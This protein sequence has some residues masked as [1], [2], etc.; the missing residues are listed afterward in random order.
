MRHHINVK[1]AILHVN[2]ALD[3]LK[4]NVQVVLLGVQDSLNKISI[5]F[6]FF[7]KLKKLNI[8]FNINR[9]IS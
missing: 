7:S 5:T 4:T 3:N 6:Y 1:I 8:L 9:C 2:N